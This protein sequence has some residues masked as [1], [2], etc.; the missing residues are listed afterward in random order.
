M[1]ELDDMQFA[2]Y[3][4]DLQ[5]IVSHRSWEMSPLFR[6]RS[7]SYCNPIQSYKQNLLPGRTCDENAQCQGFNCTDSF[8]QGY[9]SGSTCS[10]HSE[11]NIGLACVPSSEWPY[12]TFCDSFR[13]EGMSCRELEDCEIGLFCHYE[14]RTDFMNRDKKCLKM[15]S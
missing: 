6:K 14:T 9:I 12:P 11:C 2:W 7:L 10:S 13:A 8:C 5:P 15:F 1:C 3:S 4:L